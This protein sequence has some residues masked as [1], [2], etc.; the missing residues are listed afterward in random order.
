MPLRLRGGALAARTSALTCRNA[1][2]ARAAGRTWTR[3]RQTTAA[4]GR[5]SPLTVGHTDAAPAPQSIS[6]V[7]GDDLGGDAD[8]AGTAVGRCDVDHGCGQLASIRTMASAPSRSIAVTTAC[9]SATPFAPGSKVIEF[10]PPLA[11]ATTAAPVRAD[12]SFTAGVM[13]TPTDCRTARPS[14]RRPVP[15]PQA[16]AR[17]RLCHHTEVLPRRRRSALRDRVR[18]PGNGA[19]HLGYHA[20]HQRAPDPAPGRLTDTDVPAPSRAGCSPSRT[21]QRRSAR[22]ASRWR[23]SFASG[24]WPRTS[25]ACTSTR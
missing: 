25:P 6:R 12:G 3:I 4:G 23:R 21:T 24:Y 10:S 20:G 15:G 19:D 14:S 9:R 5:T 22:S 2:E 8:A 17:R 7:A 11:T 18:R 1:G 16:P 13:S